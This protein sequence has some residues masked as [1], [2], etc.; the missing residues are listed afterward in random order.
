MAETERRRKKQL[1]Y[2]AEHGITP[3]SVKRNIADILESVFER[4][5]VQVDTGLA[6]SAV[7]VGHN[8]KAVMADLEKRM[9]T[10]A[11]DLDFEE[12][13]RLRDE[14]KRLQATELA[15]ADDPMAGQAEG[16]A[17]GRPLRRQAQAQGPRLPGA[18]R[19]RPGRQGHHRR[20]HPHPPARPRRHG[21][22]HRPRGAVHL[23]RAP[24]RPL[25]AGLPGA[26]AEIQGAQGEGMTGRAGA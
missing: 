6:K 3:Q 24:D 8:L 13:A 22:G 21:P 7:T 15:I 11:A 16:R 14:L 17:R 9:R 5:H 25:D 2:N 4:D 1:A 20:G 10:A 18:A 26:E 12:A 23:R 19:L